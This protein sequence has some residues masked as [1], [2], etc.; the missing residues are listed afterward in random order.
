MLHASLP[1]G[2]SYHL[3][4]LHLR[5]ASPDEA[6]RERLARILAPFA[7]AE[8]AVPVDISI[9]LRLVTPGVLPPWR[10][11]G[12]IV[13]ESHL[14]RCALEGVS[15]SAHFPRWGTMTV[16]LVSGLI[17]G[18][19]LPEALSHYG[20]FDD[21]III[22]LGPLLRRRGFFALHAFAASWDDQAVLLVG[23]IG[24]G[25][26]TTGLSLL[27]AGWKLVS[28]DSPL[29]RQEGETVLACAY[30]GLLAA[31]DDSL[32]HFAT[33]RRFQGE[34]GSPA[35]KRV[36]AAHE[37]YG[38]AVWQQKA[39]ASLLLFPQIEPGLAASRMEPLNGPQALLALLPNSIERWDRDTIS[40]HLAILQALVRQVPAYRLRLAFDTSALPS[41]IANSLL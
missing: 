36:F 13:S 28:N 38:D 31:Y 35:A 5:V 24:A 16:D 10:P 11:A 32:A 14:L 6:I 3:H 41:M 37:A 39:Q 15:L 9:E 30:P 22:V 23:D 4:G 34:P 18:N 27:E 40:P 17:Q 20:A 7:G 8:S 29:L 1:A 2:V 25:K 21:M 33:L 19:L 26:T 12:T